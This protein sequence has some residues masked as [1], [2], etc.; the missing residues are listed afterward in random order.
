MTVGSVTGV[1]NGRPRIDEEVYSRSMAAS[2][3]V[4]KD[5]ESRYQAPAADQGTRMADAGLRSRCTLSGALRRDQL[6]SASAVTME[7]AETGG[8]TNARFAGEPSL[9]AVMTGAMLPRRSEGVKR[10]QQALLD[11][12]F[13]VSGGA[14]GIYGLGSKTAVQQFQREQGLPVNGIVDA[15]T[16]R[17]LN[18]VSPP[19]GEK[20]KLQSARFADDPRLNSILMGGK[21]LNRYDSPETV[22]KVQQALK[23]MGYNPP[24]YGVDGLLGGET[25]RLIKSFQRAQGLP[26]TGV[27]DRATLRE[28]DRQVPPPGQTL[29]KYPEYE[30]MFAEGFLTTTMAVGYDE[31]GWHNIESSKLRSALSSDGYRELNPTRA[32]DADLLKNAGYD[33][34]N[35]P[36]GVTFYNK[37]FTYQG[38]QVQSIVQF[39]NPDTPDAVKKFEQGLIK[40]DMVMYMGHARYGTG[41]DFDPKESTAGNYVIG[42][43]STAHAAGKAKPGY[44]AH[45]NE[46]LKD[47]PNSLEQTVFD[48]DKY[49][50]WA[51]YACQTINYDDEL[52]LIAKNKDSKNLDVIGSNDLIYWNNMAASGMETLRAITRGESMKQLDSRLHDIHQI[53][54]GFYT[55][56]FGDNP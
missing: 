43:N 14:D 10:I 56:G 28:I 42:V 12:G 1:T 33:I 50:L 36:T 17:M 44:D 13:K 9:E 30:K 18:F 23:D 53:D 38:K 26:V 39:I 24:L 20:T 54:N 47:T 48:K 51:F 37:P 21:A 11:L 27:I 40:S 5:G 25:A 52:R 8:L 4:P 6:T 29:D 19:P 32:A 34:A 7:I 31:D 2:N 55:D 15:A 49:Q 3:N 35:L 46:I 41:P 22:K 16:L 45:M